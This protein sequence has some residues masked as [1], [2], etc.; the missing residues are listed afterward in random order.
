LY[1]YEH[2]EHLIVLPSFPPV[3]VIRS[4]LSSILPQLAPNLTRKEK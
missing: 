1:K 3:S 2:T 4:A